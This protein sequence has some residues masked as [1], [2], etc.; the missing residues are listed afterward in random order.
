M[1]SVT[2]VVRGTRPDQRARRRRSWGRAAGATSAS[3]RSPSQPA[4]RGRSRRSCRPEIHRSAMQVAVDARAAVG[5]PAGVEAPPASSASARWRSAAAGWPATAARSASSS[6]AAA[7]MAVNSTSAMRKGCCGGSARLVVVDLDQLADERE[8][9]A[10]LVVG[11]P[12]GRRRPRGRGRAGCQVDSTGIG[13]VGQRVVP[14]GRVVEPALPRVEDR[15]QPGAVGVAGRVRA[16][17]ARRPAGGR[18]RRWH[19][20]PRRACRRRARGDRAHA[21][22]GDGVHRRLADPLVRHAGRAAS[23]RCPTCCGPARRHRAPR[24]SKTICG[25]MPF[26]HWPRNSDHSSVTARSGSKWAQPMATKAASQLHWC[27]YRRGDGRVHV[28]RS[29]VR[30]DPDRL[31]RQRVHGE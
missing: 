11:R 31:G 14:P 17:G 22:E 6:S 21:G 25:T 5:V 1:G 13:H 23:R 15:D 8:V 28:P 24:R 16:S 26:D 3:L 10:V 30:Q 12:L 18:G 9:P 29:L 4:T 2:A 7:R 19:D 20:R 27:G